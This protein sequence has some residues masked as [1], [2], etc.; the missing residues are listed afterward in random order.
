[1]RKNWFAR[2]VSLTLTAA[3]VLGLGACGK[4]GGKTQGGNV[5][6]D[7]D[8]AKQYV[9]SYEEFDM[10]D[11][12][13]DLRVYDMKKI[14][15]RIYWTVFVYHWSEEG[16]YNDLRLVSMK[17]D[18]SDL[19]M[20]PLQMPEGQNS[21]GEDITGV[22]E[23]VAIAESEEPEAA[24]TTEDVNI[25]PGMEGGIWE[26]TSYS[27]IVLS[28]NGTLYGVEYYYYE[29][30]TDPD[31]LVSNHTTTVC[32]WDL[33]GNSLWRQEIEELSGS[34]DEESG[35]NLNINQIIAGADDSLMLFLYD[36]D[37][38]QLCRWTMDS[39][40]N[41]NTEGAVFE[42]ED[43]VFMNTAGEYYLNQDGNLLVCYY[44]EQ[45]NYNLYIR[46]YDLEANHFVG[47]GV[48]MPFSLS[49]NGYSDITAGYD[50]DLVITNS[51]GVFTYNMGEEDATQ[52]MSYVNSDLDAGAIDNI[53]MMDEDHF[54]GF[55]TTRSD[56]LT[57]GAVF[58][59]V[60]PEDIPDKKVLVL[61]AFYLDW[62]TMSKVIAYNKSNADYRIV[63]REYENYATEDDYA[64]G[65]TRLNNDILSG[66]MPDI[67]VVNMNMDLEKYASKGLLADVK[68]LIAQDEELSQKEF[69]QNVF[70]AYS[71]DGKLYEVI[72]TFCVRTFVGK[73]SL[74]GDRTSWTMQDYQDV[75]AS[76]PEGTVG[77]DSSTR[78][79]FMYTVMNYCG[80][81]FVDVESGKCSFDSENF[82]S[83]L[84]Y[85]ATLPEEVTYEDDYW[86]NY[87]SLFRED[88]ALLAETGL[89]PGDSL[90]YL[91]N[92]QFG[93]DVSFV[94]F[95][96]DSEEGG[97]VI[98][99]SNSYALS[100]KSANLEGA[101][102][103]VRYYLT[104][105]YQNDQT[106]G[107]FPV[108]K[109]AF[110][111]AM[112]K[113]MQKSTYEDENGELVEYDQTYWLGEEQITLP[114]LTQEQMEQVSS[115][116]QSV[117]KPY[118]YNEDVLNIINE[119]A[120]AFF[121]GQKTAKDVAGVIQSR[122][123]IYVNENQ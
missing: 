10:S 82:I 118:Y 9:Y 38:G 26:N 72:P 52:I 96:T 69:L 29:D 117:H 48:K 1:M 47:E 30:S 86:M 24:D 45:D 94:G 93:E 88:R 55:Y 36:Y 58:T 60:D 81:D 11:M 110:D 15:D 79:G 37:N 91:I 23:P 95:P 14:D 99:K 73:K 75:L 101:W 122:V 77:I 12:G 111:E 5:S 46:A 50:T 115:F 106:G 84:E 70:D 63:V 44:N 116:V 92:G 20:I 68:E 62:D 25:K 40:G 3:M 65:Y 28:D 17:E 97:S 56:Y 41:L 2:A 100:A 61:A 27:N 113:S 31:N 74:V 71:V 107:Y 76:M 87:D 33:E 43:G 13:D 49:Y 16:M 22:A 98:W 105:E 18:G 6:Q 78:S 123:Q 54:I 85:A 114:P 59:K 66:D 8:L 67:L 34:N 32:A 35:S 109:S 83:M 80:S 51:E 112:A 7:S 89:Y 102:E 104:D 42:D 57:K 21:D 4:G 19:Q 119:E 120:A 90:T 53:L 64:A 39:E 108:S 121:A 103:F